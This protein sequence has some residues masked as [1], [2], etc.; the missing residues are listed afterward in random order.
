MKINVT[1]FKS[2]EVALKELEPFVKNGTHL[3]SGKP[4]ENLRGMRSRE[5][6]ANWLMCA[7]VNAVDGRQV[8]FS[9]DPTGGDG[10]LIDATGETFLAEHVMVPRQVGGDAA[11]AGDLILGAINHKRAK[12]GEAYAKGKTLVVFVD[13]V[14]GAWFPNPVTKALPDPLFFDAV[15]VISLQRVEDGRYIYGVTLLDIS[16]GNAP[17]YHVTISENFDSWR[18]EELQ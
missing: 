9:S 13:A 5:A 8:S 17:T 4:F 12:G 7:V 10:I 3:Q 1:R 16:T 14:T 11:D 18:V 2:L 6:L 15:W